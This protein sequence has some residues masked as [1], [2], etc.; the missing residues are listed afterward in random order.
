MDSQ[1]KF[2]NPPIKNDAK[3]IVTITNSYDCNGNETINFIND[4]TVGHLEK[5]LL[6]FFFLEAAF[7]ARPETQPNDSSRQPHNLNT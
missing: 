3:K 6:Q 2:R 4:V 1:L 5:E 7:S